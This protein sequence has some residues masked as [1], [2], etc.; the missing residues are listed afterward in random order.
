MPTIQKLIRG[1]AY[2]V[3]EVRPQP[4]GSHVSVAKVRYYLDGE[5]YGAVVAGA[6]EDEVRDWAREVANS[7]GVLVQYSYTTDAEL[8]STR[9]LSIPNYPPWQSAYPDPVQY[10]LLRGSP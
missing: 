4:A 5:K 2:D 3:E 1:T 8:S 9:A 6:T 7:V 10:A